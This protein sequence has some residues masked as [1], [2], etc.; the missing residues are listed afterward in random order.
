MVDVSQC[1]CGAQLSRYN[2][3]RLCAACEVPATCQVV[4]VPEHLLSQP[5]VLEAL[6]EQDWAT[7]LGV[8]IKATGA[9]QGAIATAVGMSQQQVSRLLSG[10]RQARTIDAI[11]DLC[12][13]LGIPRVL[14]GLAPEREVSA[15][16]RREF[17]QSATIAG[18]AALSPLP[19]NGARL[20]PAQ[21]EREVRRLRAAIPT[22]FGF[23]N[24]EGGTKQACRQATD[25]VRR[26][27]ALVEHGLPSLRL[28][29][30]A[31][32]VAVELGMIGGWLYFDAGKHTEAKASWQYALYA[33]Q[34]AGDPVQEVYALESLSVQATRLGRPREGQRLAGRAQQLAA[35][36]ASRRLRSL[37]YMREA[38]AWAGQQNMREFRNAAKRARQFYR[39][40]TTD[41]PAWLHFYLPAELDGLEGL[42]YLRAGSSK[43][44]TDLICRALNQMSPDLRRNHVYYT[45][46][47][48]HALAS[49]GELEGAIATLT[50]HLDGF[51][52]TGSMR[53]RDRVLAVCDIARQTKSTVGRNFVEAVAASGAA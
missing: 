11:R 30:E 32:A 34:L 33:A 53:A 1:R 16:D 17:I 14:A 48:G 45:A 7:V 37:L 39:P 29:S 51:A 10:E 23:H 24:S 28:N 20:T 4:R 27:D 5:D 38:S 3:G 26:A 40:V 41:D 50:P 36:W 49:T 18:A 19:W 31:Q 47:L 43:S 15:T 46:C 22:L 42:G 25:L 2:E 21:A 35:G 12:D 44:A 6:E 13:G 8:V 9:S 52:S